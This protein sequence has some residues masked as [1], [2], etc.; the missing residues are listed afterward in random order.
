MEMTELYGRALD[1]TGR[2][3]DGMGRD[4]L[5]A[6]TPCTDWNARTLLTH[7]VGGNWNAAAVAEGRPQRRR[8]D[9]DL[10]GDNPV[11]AYRQSAEA[12]K[13]SWQQPG[14]L[15]ETYEMPM[16]NL[17]G[18]MVLG[19]RLLET[20]THGWDLA[21]ATRQ[22]PPFD[23]AVVQAA[24]EIARANLSVERPPGYPFAPPVE[25]GD[26][27]PAIDQLAAFMGRRP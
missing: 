10:L 12:A 6:P 26:D 4:Q 2:I 18:R 9:E 21:Q 5:D 27:L 7:M 19:V 15:E 8:E 25:A 16:G 11:E 23:D 24:M 13:N 17:S 20:V 1:Q 3:V 22:P 14:R